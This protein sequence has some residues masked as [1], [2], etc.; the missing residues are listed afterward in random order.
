[1]AEPDRR[2][3]AGRRVMARRLRL[4]I[5]Q[6]SGDED[7]L[8]LLRGGRFARLFAAFLAVIGLF[9]IVSARVEARD[10]AQAV[11]LVHSALQTPPP[12]PIEDITPVR[13]PAETTDEF[14]R[15]RTGAGALVLE[16]GEPDDDLGLPADQQQAIASGGFFA[17]DAFDDVKAVKKKA[18]VHLMPGIP[19]E[20][21]FA[22]VV[23]ILLLSF[24]LFERH[25]KRDKRA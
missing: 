15:K 2:R 25:G 18:Y 14:G 9:W 1:S 7:P 16:E 13:P 12:P 11:V 21:F 19:N 6:D 20:A 5:V 23:L 22:G 3:R 8:E 24:S 17:A 10:T 4:P